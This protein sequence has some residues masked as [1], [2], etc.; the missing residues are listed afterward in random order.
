[1]RTILGALLLAAVSYTGDEGSSSLLPGGGGFWRGCRKKMSETAVA[2]G[3]VGG[4]GKGSRFLLSQSCSELALLLG[5]SQRA[6]AGLLLTTHVPSSLPLGATWPLTLGPEA[7][8][9]GAL[10]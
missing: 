2:P 4:A 1:M 3:E 9:G 7:V 10:L 6:A 8:R 5:W